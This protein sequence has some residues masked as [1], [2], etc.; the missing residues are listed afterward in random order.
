MAKKEES[1]A[2]VVLERTY[3]VPLRK[4]FMKAPKY[5]RAKKAGT[6]LKQFLARH[7]KSEDIKIGKYLNQLVWARGIKNPPHHV[8]IATIKYDNGVVWAELPGKPIGYPKEE[9]ES[10]KKVTAKEDKEKETKEDKTADKKE[11]AEDKKA[12]KKEAK[13][14]EK[15]AEEEIEDEEILDDEA[16]EISDEDIEEEPAVK[17]PKAEKKK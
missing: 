11:K 5:K 16:E 4:E 3:N 1:K 14:D 13:K 15:A 17:K 9:K 12:E 2:K 10:K 8:K 7:M 6:A